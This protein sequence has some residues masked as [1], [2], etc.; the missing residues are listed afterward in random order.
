MM[1]LEEV[2][3]LAFLENW[4]ILLRLALWPRPGVALFKSDIFVVLCSRHSCPSHPFLKEKRVICL[5]T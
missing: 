2:Q 5:C 1:S 3:R 4:F